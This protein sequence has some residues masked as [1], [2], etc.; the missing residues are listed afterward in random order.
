ML[1]TYL[2]VMLDLPIVIEIVD[3]P[4]RINAFLPMLYAMMDGGLV[5]LEKV[6]VLHC[7]SHAGKTA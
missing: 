6:Q 4:E 1:K 2:A 5:T 3:L 7:R